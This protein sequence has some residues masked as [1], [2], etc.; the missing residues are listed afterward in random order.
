MV[1]NGKIKALKAS[2]PG[3]VI[4]QLCTFVSV[5]DSGHEYHL[6]AMKLD[7]DYIFTWNI[8]VVCNLPLQVHHLYS[9]RNINYGSIGTPVIFLQ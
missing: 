9:S 6:P 5:H 8:Y 4:V 2:P 3:V 1:S 7:L